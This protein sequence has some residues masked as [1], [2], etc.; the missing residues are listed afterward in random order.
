RFPVNY[1]EKPEIEFGGKLPYNGE[2]DYMGVYAR[3]IN[4]YLDVYSEDDMNNL[5]VFHCPGDNNPPSLVQS[6]WF[7]YQ[8]NSYEANVKLVTREPAYSL[9]SIKTP[10]SRLMLCKDAKIFHGG[11]PPRYKRSVLFLDGHVKVHNDNEDWRRL[12]VVE[13]PY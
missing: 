4:N 8:G 3:P 5:N 11:M 6:S 12:Y 2:R 10:H 9:N 13:E 1:S 7:D